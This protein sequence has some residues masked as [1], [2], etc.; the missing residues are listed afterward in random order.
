MKP[1][2]TFPC[3]LLASAVCVGAQTP[4]FDAVS[5]RPNVTGGGMNSIRATPGR[6]TMTN[7]NLRKVILNAYGIPDDRVYALAGPEW[8]GMDAFDITATFPA[9]QAGNAIREMLKT[10]LAERFHLV[11]HTE[12]RQ[13]PNYSLVVVKS[14]P[15]IKPT[16]G[17]DPRT[18][19]RPGH[20]EAT[21]IT[22]KKFAD[23]IGHEAGRPVTDATGLEGVYDFTLDWSPAAGLRLDA[24]ESG[25]PAPAAGG[26][27]VFTA[28]EE[29]LGLRLESG[30]GP[31]EVLVVDKVE[32]TPLG[33]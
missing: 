17:S 10:M 5:I 2:L 15:K 18:S 3:L 20:F 16:A 13:A 4:S 7:V 14:G 11:L 28:L 8:L 26:P 25:A 30:K 22:M 27:S 19:S 6:V 33:N 1:R 29:Q 21:K 23:L 32:R 24:G 31:I 9:S 12:T